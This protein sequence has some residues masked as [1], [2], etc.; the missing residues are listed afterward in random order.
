[1]GRYAKKYS[2]AERI[3]R[4]MRLLASRKVTVNDLAAELGITRRQVYRDLQRI[5]EE[6]HP[7][8]R[9]GGPRD[10]ECS[11]PL[12]YKGLPPIT[13]SPYELMSLYLAK[14]HLDYLS[15]TP[16]ADDLEVVINKI[17]SGLPAKTINHLERILQVFDSHP[18]MVRSYARQKDVL[19]VLRQALLLQRTVVVH[20]QK[21]SQDKPA[22]HRVDPYSLELYE[23]GLYLVAYSHGA[24]AIRKFAVERIKQAELTPDSFEVRPEFLQQRKQASPAFGV[25]DEPPLDIRVRFSREVAHLVRE[26]SWHPTQKIAPLDNGDVLLTMRAGGLRELTIWALSWGARAEVLAPPELVQ[27]VRNH[28][29]ALARVYNP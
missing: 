21:A 29:T 20:H 5:E 27:E 15:G 7:L 10:R 19:I 14:N 1:M 18:R 17:K 24:R 28:V 8:T 4:E 6:G 2:Q 13:L 9:D 22:S 11:L 26:R 3:A 16:F 12:G 23:S 25:I